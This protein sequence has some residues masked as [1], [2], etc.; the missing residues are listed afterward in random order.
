MLH[1]IYD[2]YKTKF[3][4]SWGSRLYDF[5]GRTLIRTPLDKFSKMNPHLQREYYYNTGDR[6]STSD[7]SESESNWRDQSLLLAQ[8]RD[9]EAPRVSRGVFM[10]SLAVISILGF[11]FWLIIKI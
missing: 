5:Y 10:T 9:E 4:L 2:Q 7:I 8:V 1:K 11:I 6:G 3:G